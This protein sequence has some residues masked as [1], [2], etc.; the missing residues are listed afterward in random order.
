VKDKARE[1]K[2]REGERDRERE[3]ER[4]GMFERKTFFIHFLPIIRTT[5]SRV[6]AGNTNRGEGSVQLTSSL[7]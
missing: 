4:E 6:E 2:K 7:R 5:I 3:R 1:R